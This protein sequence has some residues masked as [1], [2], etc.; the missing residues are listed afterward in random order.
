MTNA[1]ILLAVAVAGAVVAMAAPHVATVEDVRYVMRDVTV[2]E[3]DRSLEDLK[4]ESTHQ[5]LQGQDEGE[6]VG[7]IAFEEGVELALHE[8]QQLR[9][10]GHL[11]LLDEGRG[12]LPHQSVQRG[13]FGAVTL[14][15]DRSAIRRPLGRPTD[16]LHA[17]LRSGEPTRFRAGGCASIA[18][19]AA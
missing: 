1:A 5:W 18:Q 6:A 3:S 9:A 11:S 17:R 14:A 19:S 15:V 2:K 10:D 12:M 7:Q 16:G 13:L 4:N 8:L